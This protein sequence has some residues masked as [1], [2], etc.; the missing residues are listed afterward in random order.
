MYHYDALGR[1]I[2]REYPG[3][4]SKRFYYDGQHI[5]EENHWASSTESARKLMV[6]GETIDELLEYVDID[7][8]PDKSTTRMR[9]AGVSDG[10][11]RRDRGDQGELPVQGVRRDHHRQRGV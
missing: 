1:F 10:A 11:L 5:I 2:E 7:A 8:S 9:H 4:S 6:Y 3:V